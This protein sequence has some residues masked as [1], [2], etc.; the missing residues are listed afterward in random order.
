MRMVW[1]SLL[2]VLGVVLMLVSGAGFVVGGL[3]YAVL[4]GGSEGHVRA[5][6]ETELQPLVIATTG[7]LVALLVVG[8]LSAVAG[9]AVM[10]R[11]GRRPPASPP[12][13]P[14]REDGPTRP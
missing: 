11:R 7:G 10:V 1:G 13:P 6:A 8:G 2:V 4:T 12:A 3:A 9:V 14:R 5:K